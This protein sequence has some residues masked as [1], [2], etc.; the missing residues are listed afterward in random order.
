MSATEITSSKIA[1][2]YAAAVQALAEKNLQIAELIKEVKRLQLLVN[3][4]R[5]G[6]KSERCRTEEDDD[7][8]AYL[9]GIEPEKVSDYREKHTLPKLNEFL[10]WGKKIRDKAT[11]LPKSKLLEAFSYV[12]NHWDGL[13][14]YLEHGIVPISNVIIEQQIR[15]LKLGAKN[16]LF[17]AG[18]VDAETVA[19]FNSL[20]CTCKMSGTNIQ[21]YL[22]DILGSLTDQ[23][24]SALT[25]IAWA[26]ERKASQAKT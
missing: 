26:K 1:A 17:A 20:V 7:R 3:S 21:E 16:W 19:I 5:F 12:I 2:Q 15:N 23:S 24:P 11:L 22:T 14:V 10:E 13:T 4:S 9:F 8:Q 6:S 18:E 25:P